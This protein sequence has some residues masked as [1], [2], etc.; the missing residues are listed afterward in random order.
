MDIGSYSLK[1]SQMK[2]NKGKFQLLSVIREKLQ[3]FKGENN[4]SNLGNKL[5]YV[6][7]KLDSYPKTIITAINNNSLITRNI[8][9]P[10]ITNSELDQA[11]RWAV[12]DYVPYPVKE[13][14]M[15]Y[16]V[17]SDNQ[18]E[19]RILL[20]A[21]KKEDLNNFLNP[22]SKLNLKPEVVNVQPMALMSLLIYQNKA[23]E[24][25]IIVDFGF[26]NSQIIIGD[27]DNIYLYRNLNIGSRD[28]TKIIKQVLGLDFLAAEEYKI[29]H[30]FFTGNSDDLMI[31]KKFKS[32]MADIIEE[33][34]RSLEYYSTNNDDQKLT[35]LYLTGG[36]ALLSGLVKYMN[37]KLELKVELINPGLGLNV[38]QQ[39]YDFAVNIGLGISE[40]LHNEN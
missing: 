27:A 32:L 22:F 15:K 19:L 3:M 8:R 34:S 29:N 14:K 30:N 17:I 7:G 12:A 33:I 11:L 31:N 6:F 40:V 10:Q 25:V 4:N 9:L 13:I 37:K 21:I 26:K 16:K 5:K 36:G 2:I 35:T 1:V 28:F 23:A 18:K 39:A 38:Q 20:I 24:P